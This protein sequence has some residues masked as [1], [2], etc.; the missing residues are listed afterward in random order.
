MVNKDYQKG[1]EMFSCS[2]HA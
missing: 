2:V 1:N